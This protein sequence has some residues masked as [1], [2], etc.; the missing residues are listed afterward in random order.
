MAVSFD[1]RVVKHDTIIPKLIR[2]FT[3]Y[4]KRTYNT[5]TITKFIK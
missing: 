2:L 1:H 5:V 4:T 3:N